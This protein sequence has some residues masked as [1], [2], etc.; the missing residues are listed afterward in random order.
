MKRT[1]KWLLAVTV[2]AAVAGITGAGWYLWQAIPIGTGYAA[3]YVC[4]GAFV[5]GR[6]PQ[7]VLERDVGPVNV[8]AKIIGVT[9]D[10]EAHTVT[11]RALG[12]FGSTAVYREGCGCTLAAG[13]VSAADLR[14]QVRPSSSTKRLPADLAWPQGSAG[15]VDPMPAGV[16][17]AKLNYA[18]DLAFA[19]PAI[20]TR[21]VVVAYDGNP[22]AERYPPGFHKD[23]P[24]GGWS[25]TKS[26]TNALV[27]ILVGRKQLDLQAPAPVSA[28]RA[29]GDPRRDITLGHLLRMT[30][31][32]AFEE[33]YAPLADATDMLYGSA[34]FGAYAAAK[35]LI[36]PPGTH[37]SYSTGT[38]NIICGIL[39]RAAGGG[40]QDHLAF[41]RRELF[42][43]LGMLSAL[44]EPDPSGTIVGSSYM[45]ATARDWARF[46]QLYLDDG[47]WNGERILPRG[48]V[49]YSTT[50]TP[51]APDGRYG[52]HFWLNS[53]PPGRPEARRWPELPA[54][55]YFADGFQCQ[56]VIVLP[57]RRLVVV[58]L[59]LTVRQAEFSLPAFLQPILAALPPARA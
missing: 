33:R 58:R 51:A 40:P 49:A 57:S 59:G 38:T 25:M 32:L 54:D 29:P 44:I 26:V 30:S 43:K 41:A 46:G 31:G 48:W 8:L 11:A 22:I 42:D 39:K 27:G 35:P 5:S 7:E 21:A 6:D 16:D 17:G 56:R 13:G 24:L 10:R 12:I 18:L 14:G 28:W 37:W 36:H 45:M 2:L 20:Q 55:L 52:A 19:D 34:D 47:I 4:S 23:M 50:P 15:P 1:V 3:K 53:G 9:V